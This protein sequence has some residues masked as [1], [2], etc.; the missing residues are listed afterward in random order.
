[1]ETHQASAGGQPAGSPEE[2]RKKFPVPIVI[3][4]IVLIAGLLGA[5]CLIALILTRG[6][7]SQQETEAEPGPEPL[8]VLQGH[9][10]DVN[11]IAF[12]PDGTMLAS[13]SS[14]DTVILWDMETGERLRTLR[15]HDFPGG[16]VF[17]VT[18]S[19]DGTLLASGS[20]DKTVI[21]WDVGTGEPLRTLQGHTERVTSVAWSPDGVTLASGANDNSVILWDGQTGTQLSTLGGH[22]NPDVVVIRVLSLAWSHDGAMLAAGFSDDAIMLWGMETGEVLRILEGHVSGVHSLAFSPYGKTLF[23]G[24]KDGVL[25]WDV[26]TGESQ[27]LLPGV[28]F[29]YP[30]MYMSPSPGGD[31]LALGWTDGTIWLYDVGKGEVVQT[32]EHPAF[33]SGMVL[34]WSPDETLLASGSPL[35]SSISVWEVRCLIGSC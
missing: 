10:G 18:W 35:D 13:G 2:G 6:D 16:D 1:M 27:S 8:Y 3:V 14:D 34:V 24:A 32:L 31:L 19:P 22:V 7:S 20:D 11:G 25:V 21:V 23:S 5:C 29:F 4:G 9:T 30:L 15:G 26:G 17:S 33:S 12:S 28:D